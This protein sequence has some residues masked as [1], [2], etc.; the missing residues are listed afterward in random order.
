MGANGAVV[1]GEYG[2]GDEAAEE[3][4]R[5][6]ASSYV[7]TTRLD[8]DDA[9][10]R[11]FVE[12]VQRSA[13][14]LIDG[15]GESFGINV[16]NGVKTYTESG[17]SVH[18]SDL[19]NPFISVVEHS[20]DMRTVWSTNHSD[21]GRLM[22]VIQIDKCLGWMQCVHGGNLLNGKHAGAWPA[23]LGDVERAFALPACRLREPGAMD[24]VRAASWKFAQS[25]A[26]IARESA[27]SV[28][29]S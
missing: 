13:S 29:P 4:R 18:I 3:I 27:R 22:K 20:A 21:I 25:G 6:S 9:L 7:I 8:S 12:R 1:I 19:S 2:T 26:R 23:R 5:R 17:L 10:A 28:R 15:L 11:I 24:Y 16:T 14:G